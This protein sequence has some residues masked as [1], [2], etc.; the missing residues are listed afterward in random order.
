LGNVVLR[1]KS[2]V[3]R[4]SLSGVGQARQEEVA[5]IGRVVSRRAGSCNWEAGG[6]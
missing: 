6:N 1:R 3:E 2:K 5:I 4:L